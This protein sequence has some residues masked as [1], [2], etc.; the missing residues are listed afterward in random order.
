ML[1]NFTETFTEIHNRSKNNIKEQGKVNESIAVGGDLE[2]RKFQD[3]NDIY[4]V[5]LTPGL[6]HFSLGCS[7]GL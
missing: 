3:V 6:F 1:S 4:I 5:S 7:R 2:T